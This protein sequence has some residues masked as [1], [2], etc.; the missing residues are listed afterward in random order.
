VFQGNLRN[1]GAA[2]CALWCGLSLLAI[3]VPGASM[4]LG[5]LHVDSYLGQPLNLAVDLVANDGEVVD[6]GC[7]SVAGGDMEGLPILSDSKLEIERKGGATRLLIRTLTPVNEPILSVK[8]EAGCPVKVQREYAVLLDLPAAPV[9]PAAIPAEAASGVAT[10][11]EAAGGLQLRRDYAVTEPAL[12]SEQPAAD[13]RRP[14]QR[15]RASK[16]AASPRTG[17]A[18]PAS[19]P[20]AQAGPP[21]AR[22][23][24][25]PEPTPKITISRGIPPVAGD[26]AAG[27]GLQLDTELLESAGGQ[28]VPPM[29][30]ADWSEEVVALNRRI[31]YLEA[32]LAG[33][34]ERRRTL[35]DRR[36][37]LREY[38]DM[39]GPASTD[40]D[41]ASGFGWNWLLYLVAGLV[42]G[43]AIAWVLLRVRQHRADPLRGIFGTTRMPVRVEPIAHTLPEALALR[44]MGAPEIAGQQG[45][46]AAEPEF[47][48][49]PSVAE[50]DESIMGRADVALAHGQIELALQQ[51]DEYLKEHPDESP[52]PWILALDLLHASGKRQE[53]GQVQEGCQQ[54]FNLHTADYDNWDRE[55]R[56]G[57]LEAYPHILDILAKSWKAPECLDYMDRLLMDKHDGARHGF[58][59]VAYRDLLLLRA[60][61]AA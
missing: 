51:L 14:A 6:A 15:A 11:A 56:G 35:Q 47:P 24:P 58:D 7:F 18:K 52:A 59:H 61:R 25:A 13:R 9:M 57:G 3:P 20:A 1:Y 17:A 2:V 16:K 48:A 31:A 37:Q 19:R 41:I 26:A 40:R 12:Q 54:H 23:Q 27:R 21:A 44:D 22:I 30:A 29:N 8:V 5:G 4:G 53:F 49:R 60:I 10:S 55:D 38:P 43:A 33:L 28:A 45:A 36:L 34:E 32:R 42:L 50:V 46:S 39:P